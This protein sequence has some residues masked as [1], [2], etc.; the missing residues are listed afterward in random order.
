MIRSVLRPWTSAATWWALV[1]L[2]TGALAGAVTTT[3]VL[4]MAV[5]TLSTAIVVPLALALL[6]V[7]FVVGHAMA[8]FERARY[9]HYSGVEL[10]SPDPELAAGSLWRRFVDRLRLRGRWWEQLYLV[11]RLPVSAVLF[12]VAATVWATAAALA[13]APL[14]I[15]SLPGR[16][17]GIGAVRVDP[18]AGAWLVGLAGIVLLVA[19]APRVSNALGAVD[20]AFG[21]SLLA[22]GAASEIEQ[23]VVRLESSRVAALDSAEAERR[24]IER[25]LHDGAQQRLIAA[26]MDLGVARE[27]LV[28]DPPAGRA[29]VATAHDEVKA[30]L[31]ELRDLVRGIHPVIL[32]DRG[33]DAALS[34]VV[35]RSSVPVHLD[36]RTD[37]RPS[38]AVESAAYFIVCE[39]LT[40]ITRHAGATAAS[41]SIV[42]DGDVLRLHVHD[43][44]R[45]GAN[46]DLGT[47]LTGL[48]E[49]V[50][51]LGGTVS[52]E[53]PPGGPTDLRVELP[54]AS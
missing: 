39:A 47:G 20:V 11:L 18:G 6:W 5:A 45:G 53:S 41:V 23:Q 50:S 10:R 46:P 42:A 51:A 48:A 30:A 34:A 32:E 38:P 49:R 35:A 28:T 9:R 21:R 24:R 25:D 22:H 44:G 14:Y 31:R 52:I 8:R 27:R 16:D 29:L 3:F 7:Q 54:C 36:V 37:P 17:L 15:G 33:L 12:C 19:V 2:G 43:D 4:T 1:Q 13:A 40:N 26:A